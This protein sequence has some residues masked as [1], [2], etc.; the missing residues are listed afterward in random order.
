MINDARWTVR[1]FYRHPGSSCY[2]GNV[3]DKRLEKI[4]RFSTGVTRAGEGV[5]DTTRQRVERKAKQAI[6]DGINEQEARE[7]MVTRKNVPLFT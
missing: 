3:R 5:K 2:W 6:L 4:H 7:K 1:G